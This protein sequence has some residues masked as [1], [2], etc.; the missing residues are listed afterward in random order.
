MKNV[1][2]VADQKANS[3]QQGQELEKRI[4]HKEFYTNRLPYCCPFCLVMQA[5][6]LYLH[7]SPLWGL[8]SSVQLLSPVRLFGLLTP[9]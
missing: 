6:W 4:L 8:L 9:F 1:L 3:Y 5:V 7:E 2:L